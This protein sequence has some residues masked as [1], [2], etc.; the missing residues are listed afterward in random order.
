MA[1]SRT[2]TVARPTNSVQ[3]VQELAHNS[4][5][6]MPKRDEGETLKTVLPVS[7]SVVAVKTTYREISDSVKTPEI[8]RLDNSSKLHSDLRKA[9]RLNKQTEMAKFSE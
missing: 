7:V 6:D 2:H 8:S 4:Y 9:E 5:H 1:S 3:K